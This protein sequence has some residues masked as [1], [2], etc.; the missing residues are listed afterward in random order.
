[1]II[2]YKEGEE[3]SQ[4]DEQAANEQAAESLGGTLRN[5]FVEWS[6]A[7]KDIEEDWVK[8]LRA[9]NAQYDET[10]QARLSADPNRSQIYVRL[11]RE[12]TMAAYSRIID[13]LFPAGD[14]PWSIEPT[15]VPEMMDEPSIVELHQ[16]A[17]SE[18]EAIMQQLQAEG[19][20]LQ[21]DPMELAKQ[22]V[23]EV[24]EEAA[25]EARK[26]AK[27]RAELMT[28]EMKDQ[29]EELN[30]EGVYKKSI[31]ESCMLGTGCVK[32]ATV[33]VETK[34]RWAETPDGW[35]MSSEEIAKPNVEYVSIF[36][37]Y[38]DPYAVDLND[39]SGVFH[40]HVMTKYQFRELKR[41]TGFSTDNIEETISDSPDGNHVEMTHE[42]SRRHISGQ[43]MK[44]TSNRFEVIEWWGL[45]D[46]A[47]LVEAGLEVEDETQEYEANVWVCGSKVIRA[48]L[49]PHQGGG[50]PFQLFPYERT[51]H[52]LWGTGVP[53]MMR[54][55]Q[56]TI[57]AAVRIFIDNQAISSG[58]QVEVNTNMLPAG[59]DVTDIHPWKIWLREGG[60]SATP[61]LRFYQP[62]NVSAHLTTVIELFRRF[63]D[64][65]TSMPS[66]SHGGHTP[67]MTKTASGMSMLMG[68]AS[69]AV[70]SIIKNIDDYLTSPLI[71]SLYDWNMRWNIK[72]NIKGD[73][74]IVAR[75]STSLLA[76]EVQSQRLI[77]FAQMTTNEVDL[78]LTDRRA[79]LSE[80]AKSLDLDPDK[81]MPLDDDA[82]MQA[83]AE[84]QEAQK[85][86][87]E[88][89]MQLDMANQAA[90]TAKLEAQA[91]KEQ[92]QAMLNMVDA[93][94]LPAERE[95]EAAR[96]RA[97][98]MQTAQSVQ[99]GRT[100]DGFSQ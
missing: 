18:V 42:Q 14:M 32:G 25:S 10:T 90:E 16:R 20:E 30:Y 8:D 92:A 46:G 84:Q 36:D 17:M 65:E 96:D 52:Q 83:Q 60:D 44:T 94:T 93:E 97:Y 66:Y 85:A 28:I 64:E 38:P 47:D 58:P 33:K 40:R 71:S 82:T 35:M 3:D 95:A 69:I 29:L 98:A 41:M 57:N 77:Q 89:H 5:R 9:F 54:D 79:V 34:Q 23:E 63:A 67:G 27:K 4:T 73:M 72:E 76:K 1:M 68:A 59:A 24:M 74:K 21:I 12:K 88:Q 86:M 70:K 45:V 50:L 43:L 80:V 19:G 6:D 91:K 51:P 56:D 75:G 15:S 78:P 39:L 49:N 31:M 13:L 100:P 37:V 48:R 2:D 55:S 7:R 53:K 11:T 99:Q 87:Q 62:Q 81:F 26:I 22:R 61:M